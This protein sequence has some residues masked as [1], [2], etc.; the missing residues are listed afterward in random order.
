MRTY[1]R[2]QINAATTIDQLHQVWR[3]IVKKKMYEDDVLMAWYDLKYN[4][5]GNI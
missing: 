3:Q 1:F 4:L 5:I 2:K